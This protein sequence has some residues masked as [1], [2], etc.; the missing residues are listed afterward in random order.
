MLRKLRYEIRNQLSC[1]P[2]PY[3]FLVRYFKPN[4]SSRAAPVDQSTDVVIEA[5]GRSGN[6]FAVNAFRMAQKNDVKIAHHL[7]A[8]AQVIEGIKRKVPVLVIIRN[9]QDSVVSFCLRHPVVTLSQVLRAY[10]RFYE[11]LNEYKDKIVI[12]TFDEV[13][14]DFGAVILKLNSMYGTTFKPFHH[15]DNNVE[16]C[17]KAIEDRN[18]QLFGNGKINEMMVSRPSEARQEAKENMVGML[19]EK[20]VRELFDKAKEVYHEWGGRVV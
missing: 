14:S 4:I 1:H 17:F 16:A 11:S 20:N 8:S 13:T 2:F 7:H 3:L 5:F 15:V 9:P 12:A 18:K 19:E 10:I 6:T